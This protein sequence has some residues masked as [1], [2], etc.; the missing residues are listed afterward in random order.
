[1]SAPAWFDK[2]VYFQNKLAQLKVVEPTA[3][4]TETSL[5]KAFDAAGYDASNAD[6]L[7]SHFEQYGNTEGVSPS[8][9]FVPSAYLQNK[10][11]QMQADDPTYT[12]AQLEAAL[13]DAGLSAWDH[14]TQYGAAEGL[15]TSQYFNTNE[16]LN[17]KLAQM[18]ATDPAYTMD[19]LKADLQAAGLNPI[20]H[21]ML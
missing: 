1:M 20:E 11:T 8:G 12:M 7:F 15:S 3:N 16:Y 14:Y 18:Q 10:L 13:K 5:V 6:S 19:Q 9:Y 21:Y 4:W 17:A 2:N